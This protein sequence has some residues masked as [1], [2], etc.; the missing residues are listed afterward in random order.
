[1]R[2]GEPVTPSPIALFVY[3]RLQHT[4]E[5]I[6]AL[7]RNDLASD[8]HLIVFSDGPKNDKAEVE[9]RKV[10]SYLRAVSG[11][12]AIH[13]VERDHNFGFSQS[14]VSGI[15][16]VLATYPDVIVVEDD[17]MTASNFL[18]FL[19]TALQVYRNN[20]KIFSITA[21]TPPPSNYD[22]PRILFGT[23]LSKP[24]I[25]FLGLVHMA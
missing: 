2:K 13:I 20:E 10:R 14:I 22:V 8:S 24:T 1:M 19:N 4:R 16:E 18:R 21:F 25:F 9:V 5:T 7:A 6:Q 15:S 11:F 3:S 23:R 12:R 17:I